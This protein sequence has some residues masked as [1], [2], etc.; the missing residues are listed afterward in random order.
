MSAITE[1]FNELFKTEVGNKP[2]LQLLKE[3]VTSYMAADSVSMDFKSPAWWIT[4]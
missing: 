2:A 1:L 4:N 3:E